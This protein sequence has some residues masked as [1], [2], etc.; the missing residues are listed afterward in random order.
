MLVELATVVEPAHVQEAVA[1]ALDVRALPG[2][3][4]DAAVAEFLGGRS[5]LLVLDNCEHVLVAAAAVADVLLRSAPGVSVVATS[6]EPL[7]VQ[8]ETV[9]R[10]PSLAIPDPEGPVEPTDLLSYE[11]IRLF[12][13]RAGAAA[14][15]FALEDRN[16]R[17]VVRICYRLDG[18]PLASSSP[19]PARRAGGGRDRRA[20]G[21]PLPLLRAATASA[22]ARRQTLRRPSGESRAAPGDE[23][24]LFAAQPSPEADP[25][26]QAVCSS[27]D[28]NGVRSPTCWPGWSKSL[29]T[30]DDACATAGAACSETVTSTPANGS[31][32]G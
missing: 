6:R 31:R 24:T 19:Q 14:P 23:R 5:F 1:A 18:L 29:V 27:D 26:G 12:V 21:R 9:F 25:R 7:R 30:G 3:D 32:G 15:G 11:S 13:E 10:V 16:A 2:H 22:P 20:T 8:G 28:L 4:L 17:E